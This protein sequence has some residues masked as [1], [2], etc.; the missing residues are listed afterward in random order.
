ML[1]MAYT[2]A[3]KLE[4]GSRVTILGFPVAGDVLDIDHKNAA[5]EEATVVGISTNIVEIE[6]DGMRMRLAPLNPAETAPSS[7]KFGKKPS[8]V[9]VVQPPGRFQIRT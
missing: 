3:A 7:G 5:H 9:W 6:L 4:D 1:H 8:A 2:E